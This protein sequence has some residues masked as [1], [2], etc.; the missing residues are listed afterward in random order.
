MKKRLILAILTIAFSISL[1]AQV[2]TPLWG[3]AFQAAKRVDGNNIKMAADG[4]LYVICGASTRTLEEAICFGADSIAHGSL[5]HGTNVNSTVKQLLLSKVSTEGQVLWTVY[6]QEADCSTNTLYMEPTS[7]GVVA[8]M[9]LRHTEKG[10]NL[11]PVIVDAKGNQ[12]SLEWTLDSYDAAR[13]YIG[14]VMKLDNDGALQWMRKVTYNEIA[15]NALAQ[16]GDGNFY[17][18]GSLKNSDK[19]NELFLTK[20]DKDGQVLGSLQMEGDVSASYLSTM[21]YYNGK[22]YVTGYF[23]P[24]APNTQVSIGGKTVT[25]PNEFATPYLV[26]L[27]TDLTASWA[28]TYESK[29]K[30]FT[31]QSASLFVNSNSVWL[32]GTSVLSLTTQSGKS[33][34][35]GDLTR[36]G[37]VLKFDIT[38]GN[39]LDGYVKATD[40]TCYFSALEDTEGNIYAFCLQGHSK[41]NGYKGGPM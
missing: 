35:N 34:D 17:I 25:L 2:P 12:H 28:Q 1:V 3:K 40:Q 20:L 29:K 7:D 6:S 22:I 37:S 41:D 27:N 21:K 5:Y 30:G 32:M 26:S 4:H 18:G 31:M 38:N 9:G 19:E 39:L 10:G 36:V 23:L 16:D 13:Y 8:F 15:P 14:L 33:L 11:S 24:S